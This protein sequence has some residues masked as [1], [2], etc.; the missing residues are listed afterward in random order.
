MKIV[1]DTFKSL[2][3]WVGQTADKSI[4]GLRDL[5]KDDPYDND[6]KISDISL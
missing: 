6:N 1:A 3:V 5:L 4:K 2:D